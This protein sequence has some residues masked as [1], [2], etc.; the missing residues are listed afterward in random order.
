M[1]EHSMQNDGFLAPITVANDGECIDGSLRLETSNHIFDGVTPI[2][3]ESDGTQPIV[4]RRPT[5]LQERLL[6]LL[7]LRQ[8]LTNIL[9]PRIRR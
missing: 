9:T 1:L 7:K 4:H 5:L 6:F 3:V 2:V 8:L